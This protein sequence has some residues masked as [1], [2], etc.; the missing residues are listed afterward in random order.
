MF[1][2]D[3]DPFFDVDGGFAQTAT[4]GA[5]SFPVVF[6]DPYRAGLNGFA[7]SSGPSLQVKATDVATA[8]IV[9]G[10]SLTIAG[11]DYRVTSL[12]PD[13]TGVCTV[14]VERA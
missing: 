1:V 3:L 8:S 12:Q 7:E 4:S 9:Q 11:D 13:G 6:D 2:E 5:F 14:L 10:S